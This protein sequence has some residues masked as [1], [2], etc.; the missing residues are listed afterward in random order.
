[1]R[2]HIAKAGAELTQQA[3]HF[4]GFLLLDGLVVQGFEEHV[5]DQNVVSGV[6]DQE[7]SCVSGPARN[8]ASAVNA[9]YV[10]YFS[11]LLNFFCR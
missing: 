9:T 10:M 7:R 5:Q 1:M 3:R 8:V 6:K 2:G 4:V 11:D